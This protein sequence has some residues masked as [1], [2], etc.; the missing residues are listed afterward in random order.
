MVTWEPLPVQHRQGVIQGYHVMYTAG[1]NG[2]QH[3]VT[4]G[5]VSLSAELINILKGMRYSITVAAYNAAGSGPSSSAI[6]VRS[7]DGGKKIQQRQRQRH[8]QNILAI[9]S[10]GL[11]I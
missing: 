9:A 7:E 8:G 1:N 4:V 3:N 6:V 10:K 2:Q 5:G 11:F